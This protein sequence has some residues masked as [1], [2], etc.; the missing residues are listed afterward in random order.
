[1]NVLDRYV[2]LGLTLPRVGPSDIH[3]A[4]VLEPTTSSVIDVPLQSSPNRNTP[5]PQD[6]AATA[7]S[8]D[9]TQKYLRLLP[10]PPL[11]SAPRCRSTGLVNSYFLPHLSCLAS[12]SYTALHWAS[13][14]DENEAKLAIDAPACRRLLPGDVNAGC[15]RAGPDGRSAERGQGP[16]RG[17]RDTQVSLITPGR[18]GRAFSNTRLEFEAGR[19]ALALRHSSRT[20]PLR[21]RCSATTASPRRSRLRPLSM[22]SSLS[23]ARS[24]KTA[25]RRMCRAHNR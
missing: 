9:R 4:L 8:L 23:R 6:L 13:G 1:M 12:A 20:T 14:T 17:G 5:T 21:T 24:F 15:A 22:K 18:A 16:S 3:R 11:L 2:S 7:H 25:R 10:L 19:S